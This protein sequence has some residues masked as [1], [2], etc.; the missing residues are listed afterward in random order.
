MRARPF[1]RLLVLPVLLAAFGLGRGLAPAS[2]A[3]AGVCAPVFATSTR[4]ST[5]ARNAAA[6]AITALIGASGKLKIYDGAQPTDPN[7]AL[8]AQVLLAE[9]A[10]SAD[11]FGDAATGVSTA[12]AISDDASADATGTATWFSV[13]TSGDTRIFEGS[14]GTSGANLNLNTASIVSGAAVG[15]SALTLTVPIEAD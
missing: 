11:A 8:G 1:L 9:L 7:T 3:P 10:L 5:A 14:V 12:N 13:T 6:D 15:V 2:A 4:L